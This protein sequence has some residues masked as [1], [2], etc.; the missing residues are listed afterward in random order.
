MLADGGTE[1]GVI[2]AEIDPA[3]V[4]EARRMIPS[5]THDRAFAEPSS[6]G[7]GGAERA[8]KLQAAGGSGEA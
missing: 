1:V 7:V 5:L 8:R 4:A 3:K 2:I 6:E